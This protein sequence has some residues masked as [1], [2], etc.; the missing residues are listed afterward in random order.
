MNAVG[1]FNAVS[2]AAALGQARFI[3][4]GPMF[5]VVGPG[6]EDYDDAIVEDVPNHPGLGIYAI[7]KGVGHEI[8]RIYAENTPNLKVMNVI[9]SPSSPPPTPSPPPQQTTALHHSL[10]A[11][12]PTVF[13]QRRKPPALT[14]RH[15]KILRLQWNGFYNP[16]P[17]DERRFDGSGAAGGDTQVRR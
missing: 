7:T 11:A 12:K 10:A 17:S 2:A 15:L 8:T 9:V 13:I 16:E 3:N 1:T 6:Y 14:A 5:A 4:T